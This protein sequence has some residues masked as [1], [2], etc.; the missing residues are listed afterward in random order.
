MC[1]KPAVA[2]AVLMAQLA[3]C[4][5][6][7][8]RDLEYRLHQVEVERDAL[9]GKLDDER[10]KSVALTEQLATRSRD[11]SL[12]QAESVTLRRRVDSLEKTNAEVRRFLEQMADRP[13]TRPT[14]PTSALPAKVDEA[15]LAFARRHA[16]RVWY[17]RG[18]AAVSFA[19]DRLFESGSDRVRAEAQVVL[20]ELAGIAA[21]TKPDEFEIIVVGHTDNTAI[22]N[23]Q[24]LQAHPSNWHL[25]VHRAIA[26]KNVLSSAGLPES[27]MGVMGYGPF[28]PVSDDKARNRRVEVFFVRR[29]E[30]KPL[31]PVRPH[32]TQPR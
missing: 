29:G 28:R 25:S 9:R 2:T 21:M 13:L 26:V 27:R 14:V 3:G 7:Q 12:A 23:P 1:T 11:L 18:R 8:Q 19:N 32:P 24:T 6:Q 17:E 31:P 16:G 5:S 10:A 30:V 22:V 15:L 4:V 20:G